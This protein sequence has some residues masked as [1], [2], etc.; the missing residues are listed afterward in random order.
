METNTL[1]KGKM[2]LYLL[3][4]VLYAV[5]IGFIGT[6]IIMLLMKYNRRITLIT[7]STGIILLLIGFSI[8]KLAPST[9]GKM[10]IE[11]D[12]VRIV[13]GRKAP[14]CEVKDNYIS[15]TFHYENEDKTKVEEFCL[16]FTQGE[17]YE[18]K[19]R[20]ENGNY[21]MVAVK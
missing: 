9:G 8:H 6:G 19:Y 11:A 18:I 5:S 1:K 4:L 10:I 17:T 21:T 7:L 15:I 20:Y 13:E 2:M 12:V 16:Q 3:N 14:Y